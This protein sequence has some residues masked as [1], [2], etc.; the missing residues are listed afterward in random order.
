ML[1]P[2]NNAAILRLAV[3]TNV[4]KSFLDNNLSDIENIP[5]NLVPDD[6]KPARGSLEKDR[7]AVKQLCLAALGFTP[8]NVAAPRIKACRIPLKI[9]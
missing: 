2:K 5:A 3:L 6:A 8:C 1:N 9:F 7:S 4:A